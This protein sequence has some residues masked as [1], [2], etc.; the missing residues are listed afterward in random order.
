MKNF[1]RIL[2]LVVALVMVV[3]TM[4]ATFITSSAAE[5]GDVFVFDCQLKAVGLGESTTVTENWQIAAIKRGISE[6]FPTTTTTR[7][8]WGSFYGVDPDDA[9][10]PEN[11]DYTHSK[12]ERAPAIMDLVTWQ[13]NVYDAVI[14]FTAPENGVYSFETDLTVISAAFGEVV[15]TVYVLG[16]SEKLVSNAS[17]SAAGEG[18]NIDEVEQSGTVT[19]QKGDK[20]VFAAEVN[21]NTAANKCNRTAVNDITVTLDEVKTA[22][23]A[24]PTADGVMVSVAVA[25]VAAGVAV[26][27][28]KKRH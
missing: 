2:T 5:A 26:V 8:T 24:P 13:S 19:L 17:T 11:T 14:I 21:A 6:V 27:A 3:A 18:A 12:T 25:L 9:N 4:S 23:V 22:P 28:A 1:K 10:K 15:N 7:V 16:S 20:L